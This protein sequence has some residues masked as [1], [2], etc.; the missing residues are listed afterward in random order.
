MLFL[1]DKIFTA[2]FF[3]LNSVESYLFFNYFSNDFLALVGGL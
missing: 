2:A 1:L 3:E